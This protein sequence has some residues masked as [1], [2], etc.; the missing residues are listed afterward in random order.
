MHIAF[1]SFL[2]LKSIYNILQSHFEWKKC[3]KAVQFKFVRLWETSFNYTQYTG[4][5]HQLAVIRFILTFF[6]YTEFDLDVLV[7]P[8]ARQRRITR[9]KITKKVLFLWATE[10]FHSIYM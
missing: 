3:A 8:S 5:V 4:G 1:I 6:F 9:S 7:C 10:I 2:Y